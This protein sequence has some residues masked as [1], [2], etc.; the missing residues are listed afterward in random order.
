LAFILVVAT[1]PSLFAANFGMP[2]W[3]AYAATV[4][5]TANWVR[6]FSENTGVLGVLGITW[7]LA[8]E[9][10]FY[11][12]WP[13]ILAVSLSIGASRNRLLIAIACAIGIITLWRVWLFNHGAPGQRL[14]NGFDTRADA[15]LFGCAL[16]FAPLARSRTG[17]HLRRVLSC[18]AIAGS[19]V[20][21][22]FL[23]AHLSFYFTFGVIVVSLATAALIAAEAAGVPVPVVTAALQMRWL[24]WL[25]RMSY[26]IYLWHLVVYTLKPPIPDWFTISFSVAALG[27]MRN[28]TVSTLWMA[29]IFGAIAIG[30]LSFH[31][32]EQPFLR[33]KRR[34]SSA[35]LRADSRAQPACPQSV[36]TNTT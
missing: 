33:L 28:V 4:L 9:E 12:L 29:R 14:N 7:S 22:A 20:I 34:F 26:S 2:P 3:K 13:P 5:Y 21:L 23:Q 32:I 24:R 19:F 31:V 15:L 11:L 18:S 6:A 8:I 17:P 16:A 27:E 25:G 10:Q 36:W 30:A 1:F 35:Q